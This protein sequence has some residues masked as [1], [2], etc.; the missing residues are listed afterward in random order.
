MDL[1]LGEKVVLVVIYRDLP[2]IVMLASFILTSL[3]IVLVF[4]LP[5]LFMIV[6]E[7]SCDGDLSFSIEAIFYFV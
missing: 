3:A 5:E 4:I 6:R 1:L 2:S 7:R